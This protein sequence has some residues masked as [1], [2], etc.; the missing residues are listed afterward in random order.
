MAM[1]HTRTY[2]LLEVS[3]AAYDEIKARLVAVDP[4]QAEA[5]QHE[6]DGQIVIDMHGL[7]LIAAVTKAKPGEKK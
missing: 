4:E 2:A 3:Q 6:H 5:A 1:T 7:A